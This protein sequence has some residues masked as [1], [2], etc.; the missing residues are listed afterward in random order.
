MSDNAVL[1]ALRRMGFAKDE[2]TG[3]GFRATART[4]LAERLAVPS[5]VIEAQLAHAVSDALGR[6]Y[7]R[8]KFVE[9]RRSMMKTWAA[10][11]DA[12]RK[13]ND[14]R[15]GRTSL[16]TRNGAEKRTSS[17]PR[18]RPSSLA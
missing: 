2:I 13:G 12:L 17:V 5:E 4:S 8:T 9:Q 16:Q 14:F 11:L 6:A 3:H 10:Y 18:A 15:N 1:T 7:N